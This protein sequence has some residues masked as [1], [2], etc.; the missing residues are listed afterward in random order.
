MMRVRQASTETPTG[1]LGQLARDPQ[2]AVAELKARLVEL[3]GLGTW[4]I[5]YILAME[6]LP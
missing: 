5:D 2:I 4:Q 6:V 1:V 3:F